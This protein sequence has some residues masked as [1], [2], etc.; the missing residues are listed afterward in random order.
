MVKLLTEEKKELEAQVRSQRKIL[1][2]EVKALRAQ[3]RQLGTEKDHYFTQLKQLKH[4]LQHLDEL[5]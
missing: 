5:S 3:N 2:R 1:V 4:A